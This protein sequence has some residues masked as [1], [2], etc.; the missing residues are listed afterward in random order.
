MMVQKWLEG[1]AFDEAVVAR[2]GA[3]HRTG[4]ELKVQFL[5]DGI[6]LIVDTYRQ[7]LVN[8]PE[9]GTVGH[10][11]RADLYRAMRM[12]YLHAEEYGWEI[13]ESGENGALTDK[14]LREFENAFRDQLREL[15]DELGKGRNAISGTAWFPRT[16]DGD[17]LNEDMPG[18]D[19][20]IRDIEALLYGIGYWTI[21][22]DGFRIEPAHPEDCRDCGM[23]S[24]GEHEYVSNL[25]WQDFDLKDL[26]G[27]HLGKRIR[28][29][30][31]EEPLGEIL[32]IKHY[33]DGDVRTVAGLRVETTV[34]S[35]SGEILTFDNAMY[36]SIVQV[37]IYLDEVED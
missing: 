15:N 20:M 3:S 11:F 23:Q 28:S 9:L 34:E 22:D 8:E 7:I 21:W 2:A 25:E 10:E 32:S 16:D 27:T 12:Q 4:D 29:R 1:I 26:D 35:P 13:T 30:E 6:D 33:R 36:G 18:P 24:P 5:E 31:N 17:L 14:G 37:E 19:E